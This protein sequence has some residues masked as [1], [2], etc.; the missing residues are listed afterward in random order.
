MQLCAIICEYNPLHLGH[1]WQ[2]EQAKRRFG[3][4]ICIMSG[5][6]V[7]RGEPAVLDKFTRA[8]CALKAGADA[9][10]ALPCLF[11]LQSAEGF[12][13]GA[14]RLAAGLG[15]T[16]L[17]FG[18]EL[19]Q[20]QLLSRLAHLS[21]H[22][23]PALKQALSAALS[24]GAS[25]PAAFQKAVQHIL[26]SFPNEAFLPNALLGVEYLKAIQRYNL[27][28]T[29]FALPRA[30]PYSSSQCRSGLSSGQFTGLPAY[31]KDALQTHPL[32][33]FNAM[34]PSLLYRLRSMDASA[35]RALPFVTEGLENRLLQAARQAV[36]LSELLSLC[37]TK[38]YP[39]SR[40]KRLLCCA[41]L[42]I[43]QR[44]MQ[45][46]NRQGPTYAQL[47]AL[48]PSAQAVRHALKHSPLPICT[49]AAALPENQ[50]LFIEQRATDLYA[51]LSHQPC[52]LDYTASL[53]TRP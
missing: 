11:S 2:I 38:R 36:T 34:E 13:S 31:T 47:L 26:P 51:L 44:D 46:A 33:D 27:Q 40:I 15:A 12:A 25:Y 1:A 50:Q 3:S 30:L 9:V 21:L 29:P 5:S 35:F 39:L 41:Y 53:S 20:T 28:I 23:P 43:T 18:S 45:S 24:D 10:F 19:V 7:Q 32:V 8:Q 48:N 6:F 52:G 17:C 37:Q 49:N 22:E 4:V 42:S 14:V 16:H